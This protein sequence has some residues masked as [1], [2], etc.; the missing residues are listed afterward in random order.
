M[1]N[2][3]FIFFIIVITACSKDSINLQKILLDSD[4]PI[5][6]EGDSILIEKFITHL[7]FLEDSNRAGFIEMTSTS[8]NPGFHALV[9]STSIIYYSNSNN[10]SFNVQKTIQS[11]YFNMYPSIQLHC[12]STVEFSGNYNGLMW[13]TSLYVP[14]LFEITGPIESNFASISKNSG[15]YIQWDIDP[16][17]NN[18]KGIF[19]EVS[20]SSQLNKIFD[21]TATNFDVSKYYLT[22]DNGYFDLNSSILSDFPIESVIEVT[23]TKGNYTNLMLHGKNFPISCTVIRKKSFKLIN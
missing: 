2:L 4:F 22:P 3:S 9:D 14:E 18:D 11:D 19:L 8:I 20:Y 12:G 16:N 5:S 23:L 17:T 6:I 15:T 13:D 1:K 21:S 7:G 10:E